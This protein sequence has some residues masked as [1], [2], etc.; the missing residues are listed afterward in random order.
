MN[1]KSFILDTNCPPLEPLTGGPVYDV[2]NPESE[3][4]GI[5]AG[6]VQEA[7]HQNEQHAARQFRKLPASVQKRALA[8]IGR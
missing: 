8:V 2:P 1:L 6:G 5:T 7:L 3:I 4:S